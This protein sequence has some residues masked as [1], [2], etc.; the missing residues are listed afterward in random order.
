L[1]IFGNLLTHYNYQKAGVECRE[2]NDWLEIKIRTPHAEADLHVRA[3]LQSRPAP[4]P[5]GSPFE[6][7]CDARKFAGPLSFTFDYEPET[8]SIIMIRGV[9]ENW[10]PQPVRVETI[11]NTFFRQSPFNETQPTLANAFHIEGIP[12]KWLRGVREP[13]PRSFK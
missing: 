12:Y 9:R 5:N 7:V 11:E 8:H 1:L 13:L 4:L 6:S 3:D 2:S 10:N